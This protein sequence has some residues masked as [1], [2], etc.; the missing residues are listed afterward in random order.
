MP[1]EAGAVEGV[2]AVEA[3]GVGV[4]AVLH[5]EAMIAKAANGATIRNDVFL[6]VKV[7]SPVGWGDGVGN[8][9]DAA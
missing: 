6:V 4:A 5:A 8:A 3:A 2:V 7:R 9:A 1:V